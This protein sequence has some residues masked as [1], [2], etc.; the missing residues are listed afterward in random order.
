MKKTLYV[1]TDCAEAEEILYPEDPPNVNY[2]YPE[3]DL[4][5]DDLPAKAG[6]KLIDKIGFNPMSYCKFD[7]C[8]PDNSLIELAEKLSKLGLFVAIKTKDG[9]KTYM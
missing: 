3:S 1:S 4:G 8:F 7:E 6:Q 2:L 9:I 5:F